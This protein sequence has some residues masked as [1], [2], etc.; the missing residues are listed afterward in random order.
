MRIS[1]AFAAPLLAVLA[2]ACADRTPTAA[3]V[4]APGPQT[5][6]TRIDCTVAVAAA[7]VRCA[8]PGAPAGAARGNVV[9]GGQ[10]VSVRLSSSGTAYDGTF[11]NSDVTV[12]NLLAQ[13]MGTPDGTT[14]TG[15]R[16]FFVTGPS[17]TSGSGEAVVENADGIGT[18][19]ASGQP[20]FEYP[21]VLASQGTSAP[22]RWQFR[23]APTVG[24]FAFTLYVDTQL[25]A[26]TGVLRW[27]RESG[28]PMFEQAR[29][30]AV[31]GT[32]PTNVFVGT[33]SRGAVLHFD[34]VSWVP[35]AF[36][37][38]SAISALWGSDAHH[39]YGAGY[40]NVFAYDGNAWRVLRSQ[41]SDTYHGL[42]G[43]SASDF[44]V[45]GE[46]QL[47]SGTAGVVLHTTDGGATFTSISLPGGGA[48]TPSGSLAA[49]TGTPGG[50]VVAVGWRRTT[51]GTSEA[52]A[53]SSQDGG[54]TWSTYVVPWPPDGLSLRGVW[55]DAG[56]HLVAVGRDTVSAVVMHSYD[57]GATWSG[58]RQE[59]VQA[60]NSVWGASP[61]DLYAVGGVYIAALG[62]SVGAMLHSTD[63]G[64]SWTRTTADWPTRPFVP[65][66]LTSV[67]AAPGFVLAG[68]DPFMIFR[69]TELQPQMQERHDYALTGVAVV[70]PS[71]VVAVGT[72][73]DN[74]LSPTTHTAVTRIWNGGTWTETVLPYAQDHDRVLTDLWRAPG[75]ELVAVGSQDP[76]SVAR[77]GLVLRSGDGGQS[78]AEAT[79]TG[80]PDINGDPKPVFLQSVWGTDAT[81][82]WAAGYQHNSFAAVKS[83]I[84]QPAKEGLVLRSNDGGAT[85]T[86][87]A[88]PAVLGSEADRFLLGVAGTDAN[89]VVAVGYDV[90]DR[91]GAITT[92][93]M[94][95]EN[96]GATWT[97][98]V[99][100][101]A[102]G[103]RLA[104]VATVGPELFA[105]GGGRVYRSPD[106]GATWALSTPTILDAQVYDVWGS[107]AQ[108]VYAVGSNGR[109]WRFDGS[110]WTVMTSITLLDLRAVAG[111]TGTN[112]YAVGDEMTIL[113]GTH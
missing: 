36:P 81:H 14:A 97:T 71:R 25:P 98:S 43:R 107:D 95:T 59:D 106:A 23:V 73:V 77:Q 62:H 16:V 2:A 72:R 94:R 87:F 103:V 110:R 41:A 4:A 70:S 44:F 35:M 113:H 47:S 40:G 21:Q 99:S 84:G 31:W 56:G 89:H 45:V 53:F 92:V 20:Y 91:T 1:A 52:V 10:G 54:A 67:W 58:H 3:L 83:G 88:F 9:V 90:A 85:W 28:A 24:E 22:R 49:V 65:R 74:H 111:G 42:W 17:V 11:L 27:I 57:A 78:W 82:L 112:V 8:A 5:V 93:V 48:A 46:R 55:A 32:S 18:F 6:R 61:T 34:G 108:H 26:E 19:T 75:G 60:L 12:Q 79:I 39:V 7:V 76:W 38:L 101:I 96:G 37:S 104:N 109:A 100:G 69:G 29:V 13:P 86:Q 50:T 68:G 105:M 63:A 51:G 33:E 80:G 66:E 30:A 15:V 64:A 102:A